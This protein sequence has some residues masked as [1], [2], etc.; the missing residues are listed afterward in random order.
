MLK[1]ILQRL[2]YGGLVV[3]GVI[4]VVFFIFHALP[5][6]PAKMIT[7]GRADQETLNFINRYYGLDKPLPHQLAMYLNDLSI[8]SVHAD[9]PENKTEYEFWVAIPIGGSKV[10]ALKSP[11]FRRSYLTNR[12][13]SEVI[14]ENLDG[15]FWLAIGA[16]GFAAFWGILFGILASLKPGSWWDHLLISSSVF[17]ISAPSFVIGIVLAMLFG[18]HLS[19]YTGLEMTGSLWEINDYGE[20]VLTPKNLILPAITLGL[21]PLAIIA[22]LMRNS[23]LEVF[24]QDY[25]RTA[26]AKGL[27]SYQIVFKHALKNALNPVVTAISSWL[28]IM[29]AGAFFV[30]YIFSWKGLGYTTISA[31]NKLDFPIIMGATVIVAMMFVLIN[32]LVDI[33][34]AWLDPRVRLH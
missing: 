5:G 22:Q 27:S 18:Y 32:I 31:V 3:F 26:K 19:D 4:V 1:F 13:V 12:R 28:A 8:I 15:T 17:G 10:L 2:L 20:R 34:Y 29:L 7:H 6:D 25:I 16:M 21:K 30:E 9:T 33:L 24:G 23:M 14:M 11:Y